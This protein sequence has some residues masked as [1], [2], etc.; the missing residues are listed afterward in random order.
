LK[1]DQIQALNYCAHAIEDLKETA[2]ALQEIAPES[3]YVMLRLV[4][5]LRNSIKFILPNCCNLLDIKEVNQS[6]LDLI[7]L[8]YSCVAFE[9]PWVKEEEGPEW[10]GDYQQTPATKRIALCWEMSTEHELVPGLN[11]ILNSFPGGGV[12]VVPLFWDQVSKKWIVTM[13]GTFVPYENSVMD[14]KPSEA[15]DS[16]RFAYAKEF[17][18]LGAK[19]SFKQFKAEPFVLLPEVFQEAISN[20]GSKAKAF[21]QIILDS[22]DEVMVLMQA[23]NVLNCAN[24][25]TANVHAP[26]ALN[27]KRQINGKQPFFSYKVLQLSEE[28]RGDSGMS[29]GGTHNSPRTHLRRGHLRRLDAKVVWVRPSMVN[30]GSI[31]GVVTKDY[32]IA[33]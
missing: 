33:G 26:D 4:D 13:G 11:S 22:R 24:V 3:S 5:M 8:P 17:E 16:T 27:K 30:F 23:C 6:N 19:E 2:A 18:S 9:A 29:L 25:T 15:L 1:N 14:L 20:Y 32:S 7:R 12:L 28:R 31:A 10:I 21:G